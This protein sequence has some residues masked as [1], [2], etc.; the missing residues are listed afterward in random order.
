MPKN[1]KFISAVRNPSVGTFSTGF[2]IIGNTIAE[3]FT[4]TGFNLNPGQTATIT[5]T[6]QVI[7]AECQYMMNWSYVYANITGDFVGSAEDQSSA[8]VLCSD[9]DVRIKKTVST[10]TV[11]SGSV[12]T[13]IIDF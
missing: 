11:S 1:I 7:G 12:V 4:R 3:M 13:Y 2:T 9:A 8:T 6:A 5:V 10:G